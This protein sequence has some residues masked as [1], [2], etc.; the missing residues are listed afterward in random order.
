MFLKMV[1]EMGGSGT[2]PDDAT[3]RAT[4]TT[5]EVVDACVVGGGP[6]GLGAAREIAR[7][8]PG[9]RVARLRRAGRAGRIAARRA[10]RRRRARRALADEARAAGARAGVERDRHRLLSRRTSAPTASPGVLAVA[11]DAGLVRVQR[12]AHAVRD[13][14]LRS[15]PAVR[16]QRSPGRDRRRARCGRLAFRWG[17]RPVPAERRAS[18]SWT[19]RRRP[20]RWTE[21]LAATGR[22]GRARRRRA[23]P[24]VAAR[25]RQAASRRRGGARARRRRDARPSPAIW[26]RSRRCPRPP[27]SCRASTARASRSTPRAAGSRPSSTT[28]TR[29]SVPGVFACGDVTGFAG[30]AAAERAGAAA[31]RALASTLAGAGACSRCARPRCSAPAARRRRRRRRPRR[32][33][34]TAA[35]R[36]TRVQPPPFAGGAPATPESAPTRAPRRAPGDPGRRLEDRAR[37]ALRQDAGRRRLERRARQVRA[38]RARRAVRRRL[39]PGRSTR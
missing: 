31:G 21:A 33:E 22:R 3:R 11:T 4:A 38:A 25:G 35:R 5:D 39:L 30:T 15:E 34:A 17:I 32:A 20:R 28:G 18:S 6:A 19:R 14:R 12:A 16:R 36:P 27:P 29:P 13:G 23:R 1:R 9:A 7:A 24:A 10:R 37:Q 2:L 8:A 26:S